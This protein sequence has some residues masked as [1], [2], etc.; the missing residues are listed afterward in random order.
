MAW[1][2]YWSWRDAF[3]RLIPYKFT[4]HSTEQVT[5]KCSVAAPMD[6]NFFTAT[7]PL[8]VLLHFHLYCFGSPCHH[9]QDKH[10][11][12]LSTSHQAT[13]GMGI[14]PSDHLCWVSTKLAWCH[15]GRG[16]RAIRHGVNSNG[17]RSELWPMWVRPWV[18]V[19]CGEGVCTGGGGGWGEGVRV[20]RGTG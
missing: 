6:K 4:S 9:N 19:R 2:F 7:W 8:A 3:V 20:L 13:A 10:T 15:W 5:L 11:H 17:R 1:T 12:A 18:I 16:R 14:N